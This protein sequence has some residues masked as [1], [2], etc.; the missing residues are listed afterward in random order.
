LPEKKKEKLASIG[1]ISTPNA[2]DWYWYLPEPKMTF[3]LKSEA[4][5]GCIKIGF[6]L[7]Y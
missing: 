5:Q 6:Q 2:E 7:Y 1:S 4:K 3:Q